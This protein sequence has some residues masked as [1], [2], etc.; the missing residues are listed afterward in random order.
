VAYR[1]PVVAREPKATSMKKGLA[2]GSS[3]GD[4]PVVVHSSATVP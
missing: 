2:V 3:G 1:G 4:D